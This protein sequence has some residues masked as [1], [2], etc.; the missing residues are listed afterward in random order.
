MSRHSG[1]QN[2]YSSVPNKGLVIFNPSVGGG[3]KVR[4]VKNIWRPALGGLKNFYISFKG[5]KKCSYCLSKTFY[6]KCRWV[7]IS[8]FYMR[9]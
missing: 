1:P 2:M 8:S 7:K 6:M 4:G 9:G 5:A 3:R